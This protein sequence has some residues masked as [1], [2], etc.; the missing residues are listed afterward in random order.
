M[1]CG[2]SSLEFEFTVTT[3]SMLLTLCAQ[4][5]WGF[6]ADKSRR[7]AAAARA[8][9]AAVEGFV[10]RSAEA[11]VQS[12]VPR[13]AIRGADS[14]AGDEAGGADVEAG[15]LLGLAFAAGDRCVGAHG[16]PSG[17]GEGVRRAGAVGAEAASVDAHFAWCEARV[18]GAQAGWA[19]P[20]HRRRSR[21]VTYSPLYSTQLELL[22]TKMRTHHSH[23][24]CNERNGRI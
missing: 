2:S 15:A 13:A 23:I 17:P 21:Q 19:L 14:G 6:A 1:V 3:G 7:G 11:A 18:H 4:C 8:G 22:H 24:P 16:V 12:G 20:P 5:F 10:T 9:L